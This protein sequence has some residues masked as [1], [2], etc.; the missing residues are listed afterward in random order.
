MTDCNHLWVP[1]THY[2]EECARCGAQQAPGRRYVHQ[3][4]GEIVEDSAKPIFQSYEFRGWP[5]TIPTTTIHGE[6]IDWPPIQNAGDH[7]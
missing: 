3:Q 2:M 6:P 7:E 1:M 5:T 4:S